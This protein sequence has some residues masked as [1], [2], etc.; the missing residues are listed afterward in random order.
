MLSLNRTGVKVE[1]DRFFKFLSKDSSD[2]ATYSS[3]AYSQARKKLNHN[4]F[5]HLRDKHLEYFDTNATVKK[6]WNNYRVV[7][8]D[9]SSLNLPNELTLREYFGETK[10]QNS[11]PSTVA[12]IS[13]AYDVCN[14]LVLDASIDKYGTSEQSLAIN[15]LDKLTPNTDVLVF[16]RGYPSLA[17]AQDLD[18]KG[19]KFCFRLSTA[20]KEAYQLLENQED[21]DWY[22]PKGKRYKLLNGE[23]KE[24]V[25]EA[26]I[27]NFRLVSITLPNGTKEVLLTNLNDRNKFTIQSLNELYKMRWSI[28]EC[29][30]KLKQVGQ[31]EYFSGRTVEAI[32]QDFYSRIVM[33]NIASMIETQCVQPI[34]ETTERKRKN[35][36]K[37]PKQANRTQIW[38]K[39]KD[40]MY[41]IFFSENRK[42][43]INKMLHFMYTCYDIVRPNRSFERNKGYKTKRKPLTYKAF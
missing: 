42:E 29:Y 18:Q 14:Q 19:F 35:K 24:S 25:L 10:N 20:W 21:I 2:I 9:G 6:N 38:A 13:I 26:D 8:I 17:F 36:P 34:I 16:D 22:L 37:H 15:H 27:E 28:E 40:F 33:L 4:V 43:A 41:D 31:V 7:A 39:I 5:I 23:G 30:K 32:K 3:S 1:I 11:K 12:K